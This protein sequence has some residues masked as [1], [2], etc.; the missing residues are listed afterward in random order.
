MCVVF[1]HVLLFSVSPL[2]YFHSFATTL[3]FTQLAYKWPKF[4]LKLT[5]L[6]THLLRKYELTCNLNKRINCWAIGMVFVA[7]LEH[8]LAVTNFIYSSYCRND[9]TGWEYLFKKQ[10]HFIF[11][12]M[13]YHFVFGVILTVN[14]FFLEIFLCWECCFRLPAGQL[15]LSGI[16]AICLLF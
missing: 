3:V 13:P 8:T 15:L 14:L 6:E 11:S 1:S 2:F 4:M 16:L 12:Y 9:S 7:L 10:F 5:K